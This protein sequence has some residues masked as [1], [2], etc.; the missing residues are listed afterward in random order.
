MCHQERNSTLFDEEAEGK[1]CR[2]TLFCQEED[3]NLVCEGDSS[4]FG[5]RVK[6]NPSIFKAKK[7]RRFAGAGK[8]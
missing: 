8:R 2:D 4:V 5:M 1:P 3:I 6:R 7:E